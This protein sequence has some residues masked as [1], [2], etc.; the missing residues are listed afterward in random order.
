MRQKLLVFLGEAGLRPLARNL[1]KA[2][3][4]QAEC[5]VEFQ[6]QPDEKVVLSSGENYPQAEELLAALRGIEVCETIG[7]EVVD[8]VEAFVVWLGSVEENHCDTEIFPLP[9]LLEE[10]RKQSLF[11]LCKSKDETF[12]RFWENWRKYYSLPQHFNIVG[13]SQVN[14]INKSEATDYLQVHKETRSGV[15]SIDNS[16]ESLLATIPFDV[17]SILDI[18]SGPGYVNRRFPPDYSI[19]A[20]DIDE[21]ILQGNIRRTCVGD[22]MD[23]PLADEAVDMIMACDVLEHLTDDVLQKGIAEL[24]RVS[25]KYLYLQVPFQED[26][27]MSIAY[28]PACG[29]V[30]HVNHHKRRFNQH[31][32]MELLSDQWDALCI[33]YTGDVSLR[34][35]GNLEQD[36]AEHLDWKL[37][38]VEG[39][40]CPE[41]GVKSSILGEENKKFVRRLAN[42][43]TEQ[44][45][46]VYTEIG[47]LFCRKKQPA[48]QEKHHPQLLPSH[49]VARRNELSFDRND[50]VQTVYTGGELIPCVYTSACI[51]HVHENVYY[52]EHTGAEELAWVAMAFPSLQN[53]YTEIEIVGR[54]VDSVGDIAVG[55]LDADGKEYYVQNWHWNKKIGRY[56][57]SFRHDTR[58]TPT[59]V[60]LYFQSGTLALHSCKLLGG[61]DVPYMVFKN[62]K[63]PFLRFQFE[64]ICYQLFVPSDEKFYLSHSPEK[65]VELTN[66]M[67]ARK[68]RALRRF[69]AKMNGQ[70]ISEASLDKDNRFLILESFFP[71]ECLGALPFD[72]CEGDSNI[73][74]NS[75]GIQN[76]L[77]QKDYYEE[78]RCIVVDSMLIETI[79]HIYGSEETKTRR[80]HAK[81][82]VIHVLIRQ[83]KKM[84]NW[85]R[86]HERIYDIL[87]SLGLKEMYFRL[88]R[89]IHL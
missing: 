82:K 24:E 18:G 39:A 48:E 14:E 44:P 23:I 54:M 80:Q 60:K 67:N 72:S 4:L 62:D 21:A 6:M 33:N 10:V 42:F 74:A 70:S 3:A 1:L 25:R 85:L 69:M 52:F 17:E 71:L 38:C 57:I 87:I 47:I 43:D 53:Q 88:R 5:K 81:E 2:A 35:P 78:A 22:I 76:L 11:Y 28:C 9:S 61:E 86:R 68:E 8:A 29:N 36:F 83:K 58:Y 89:R 16:V 40:V 19:L 56:T 75:E 13:T 41:C 55:M 84:H 34:R 31:E 63:Q 50:C 77:F 64:G 51:M 37:Y 49:G 73:A 32:L 45:F 27:L 7:T 79:L 20:M 46:P 12:E 65:W 30:W 26:P 15:P 66:G 59:F